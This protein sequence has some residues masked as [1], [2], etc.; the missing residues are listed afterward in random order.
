M[1]SLWVVQA[2][3]KAGW[4]LEEHGKWASAIIWWS[5]L[6]EMA[7]SSWSRG[8]ECSNIFLEDVESSCLISI[9]GRWYS[10]PEHVAY[11]LKM[12]ICHFSFLIACV[13][14]PSHG[15]QLN[16]PNGPLQTEYDNKLNCEHAAFQYWVIIERQ[17]FSMEKMNALSLKWKMENKKG[18]KL[19]VELAVCFLFIRSI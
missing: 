13:T 3:Q 8:R 15:I 18:W 17:T 14:M 10:K 16:Q 2:R 1:K 12:S 6:L 11:S 19:I 7:N 5:V 9:F 4:N